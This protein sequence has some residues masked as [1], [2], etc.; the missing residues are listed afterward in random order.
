M[1][2]RLAAS[3]VRASRT[4][5]MKRPCIDEM[6][7]DNLG[8]YMYTMT[9]QVKRVTLNLVFFFLFFASALTAAPLLVLLPKLTKS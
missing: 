3:G 2:S 9:H 1:G 8:R 6:L 7:C 4:P 5:H